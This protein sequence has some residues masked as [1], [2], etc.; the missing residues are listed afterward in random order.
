MQTLI[1]ALTGLSDRAKMTTD[2]LLQW[3]LSLLRPAPIL[4]LAMIVVLWLGLIYLL[5][6]HHGTLAEPDARRTI[7]LPVV[8]VLTLLEL[9]TMATSVRRQLSL[10]QTNMRFNTALENM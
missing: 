3:L 2:R 4:G 10:E 1:V 5:A 7:F 8:V 6:D 9:I